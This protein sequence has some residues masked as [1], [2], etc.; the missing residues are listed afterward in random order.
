MSKFA[1]GQRVRVLFAHTPMGR[2]HVGCEAVVTEVWNH[3]ERT[4]YGLDCAPIQWDGEGFAAWLDEQ[5][6]PVIPEG[7][8]P[9]EYSFTELMDKCRAGEV[10][11]V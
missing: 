1:V 7:H 5:L 9:S 6:S 4:G 10:E 11:H 2:P 3:P 8:Q